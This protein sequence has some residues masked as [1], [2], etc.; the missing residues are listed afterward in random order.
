MEWNN[1]SV[2][3]I[4][5]VALGLEKL[6]E[7]IIKYFNRAYKIKKGSEDF[8]SK[9]D[10]HD[11]ELISM[12][13]NIDKI[14][15][16]LKDQE[17]QSKKT[18]CS[19]LRNMIIDKYKIYK[20]IYKEKGCISALDYENLKEMFTQYFARGGNHLISKIYENFKT[21]HVSLDDIEL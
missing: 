2:T 1:V 3:A 11:K 18:D 13:G 7:W 4:V 6:I 16:I 19:I 21:W 14:F 17:E 9:V 5:A 10:R 12:G 15:S 20:E 8:H